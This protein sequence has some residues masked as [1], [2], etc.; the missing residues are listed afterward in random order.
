[1]VQIMFEL[2]RNCTHIYIRTQF[3][4]IIIV[5]MVIIMRAMVSFG[6]E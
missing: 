2:L 5:I 4:C 1:M 6:S 3:T